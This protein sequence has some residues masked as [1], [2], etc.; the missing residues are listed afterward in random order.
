MIKKRNKRVLAAYT[1][2]PV[3]YSLT[4]EQRNM[5]YM[6]SL[7]TGTYKNPTQQLIDQTGP[8]SE[9]IGQFK[10]QA[11]ANNALNQKK[12]KI[13][14]AMPTGNG[15]ANLNGTLGAVGG[16]LDTLIDL[17][18][19]S[20]STATTSGQAAAQSVMDVAKGGMKGAQIGMVAGGPYG[21]AIGAVV[22][23]LAGAIGKRGESAEMTSFT[24]YDE[25]T[26]GTGLIGAFT[27]K[28]L[29]RE[30][31]R[32]K[33]NALGNRQAVVGTANLQNDWN[34]DYGGMNTNTFADGGVIP[35]SLVYADDGELINTPDGR[36]AKIPE[37]GKPT[38]SNLL[39]LPVGSRILSDSL[40]VP[41]TKE[42]F[43]K[44]GEK[45]MKKKKS[46]Y[47]D[48]YAENSQMLND[49]NDQIAY[50][51]LFQLQEEVKKKKGIK[52]KTKELVQAAE[53]GDTVKLVRPRGGDFITYGSPL[54]RD[55]QGNIHSFEGLERKLTSNIDTSRYPSS[56]QTNIA[57]MNSADD[58]YRYQSYLNSP[59]GQY[60]TFKRDATVPYGD[61]VTE[62]S[63]L[64]LR[65]NKYARTVRLPQVNVRGPKGIIK[66]GM[67]YF[68]Q[69][70]SNYP[71]SLIDPTDPNYIRFR[72]SFLGRGSK[73]N[74]FPLSDALTNAGFYQG[75]SK[76]NI[77]PF[78]WDYD[79]IDITNP[80]TD[81]KW[82]KKSGTGRGVATTGKGTSKSSVQTEK[83]TPIAP[84]EINL[85]SKPIGIKVEGSKLP[86]KLQPLKIERNIKPK[87]NRL[88]AFEGI[89]ELTPALM[90]LF[91]GRPHPISPN[92]NPYAD[93]ILNT[94]AR[95]RYNVDPILEEI[96]KN[97]AVSNYN[98]NQLATNTGANLAMNIANT[99]ATDRA[100]EQAL[101][102]KSNMDNQYLAEYI[103]QAN[104]LGQQWVGATNLA[105]EL[106]RRQYA[107]ARN[108]RR[109][110]ASQISQWLQN[111]RLMRNQET[112]D[113]ALLALYDPFLRSIYKTDTFNN[114]RNW[115]A[116]GGN[117]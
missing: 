87:T 11:D 68:G 28:R 1:G 70:E 112:R 35:S 94:A 104:N 96:R 3:D 40:K 57:R 72:D 109:Q 116:K 26:L 19:G 5:Q 102:T 58:W 2:G 65:I 24:D 36:I 50:D 108:I 103:N 32:I 17:A 44:A 23:L 71:P 90:N 97:R 81:P 106:N 55:D 52:P 30:R 95:R 60:N 75:W 14:E 46:Q 34:L 98:A 80:A 78:T 62:G 91:E 84:K 29:K 15:G 31:E 100:I 12:L 63:E 8:I 105:E 66:D 21:A 51:K 61:I 37:Q 69:D 33:R 10:Q 45:L 49:M 22:G 47:K 114:W 73:V 42:T 110:G 82:A 92:Y 88:D 38:D 4:P 56:I 101:A 117:Q 76:G 79:T 93:A 41:G 54:Y 9:Q 107:N 115:I 83:T 111:R 27:N 99:V 18:P 25:G 39:D 67:I 13:A 86:T 59:E 85:D 53:D 6:Q 43:A 89:G 113:N 16:G 77:S 20:K 64:P 74:W 48:K 7:L